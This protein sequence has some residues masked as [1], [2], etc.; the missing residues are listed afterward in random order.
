MTISAA[1]CRGS[2]NSDVLLVGRRSDKD[3]N[4]P[5]KLDQQISQSRRSSDAR[6]HGYHDVGCRCPSAWYER[7]PLLKAERAIDRALAPKKLIRLDRECGR[8]SGQPPS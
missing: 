1:A 6:N 8:P 3:I 7:T 5:S 4:R 2:S